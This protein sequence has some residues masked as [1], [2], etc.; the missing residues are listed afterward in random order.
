VREGFITVVSGLPRSGTSLLMQMLAAGGLPPLTDQ[1]RPTDAGNPRGYYECEAVKHLATESRWL[2]TAYSHAVKIVCPLVLLLPATHN[3]RILLMRRSIE[4]IVTSQRSLLALYA[5]PGSVVA[6][7][8]LAEMF[9]RQLGQAESW[10]RAQPHVA[11]LT[12]EYRQTL[13]HP[14]ESAARI[15]AFLGGMLDETAMAK[16]VDPELYR[17]RSAMESATRNK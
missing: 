5:K 4:E 8:R 16:V 9:A 17:A 2:A 1:A 15:N 3:Y 12:V 14:P 13:L 7:A 10:M 11:F 6:D